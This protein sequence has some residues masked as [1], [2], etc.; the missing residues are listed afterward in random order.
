MAVVAGC[1]LT[2]SWPTI[3]KLFDA[4]DAKA[5]FQFF[6]VAVGITIGAISG[7]YTGRI[8]SRL[9]GG[10]DP[11]AKVKVDEVTTNQSAI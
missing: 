11:S 4:I 5:L 10:N 9:F 6:E 2:V 3:A 7:A 1:M 8:M